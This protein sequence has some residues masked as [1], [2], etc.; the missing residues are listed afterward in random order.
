[1]RAVATSGRW[2]W[3]LSGLVTT[4][5][6]VVAGTAL[7]TTAGRPDNAQPQSVATRTVTVPQ[8]VTSLTVQS[9][10]A[11]VE[12]TA[13]P[14]RRV[15]IT[16]TMAYDAQDGSVSVSAQPVSAQPVGAQPVGAQPRRARP[17]RPA[18]ASPRWCSRC[19]AAASAS[20]TPRA[21]SP[22][23]ASASR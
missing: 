22:T 10:G 12:M 20:V 4:A 3:G 11:P 7:I 23:A 16:E 13:G 17:R 14:V 1:M 15:Q 5:A 2:I 21:P 8:P 18:A 9:Y 19:P 6:L